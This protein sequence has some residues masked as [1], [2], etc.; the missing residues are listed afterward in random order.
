MACPYRLTDVCFMQAKRLQNPRPE[1]G[2]VCRNQLQLCQAR[3]A[4]V[5]ASQPRRRIWWRKVLLYLEK[6]MKRTRL[7]YI[8]VAKH[9]FPKRHWVWPPSLWRKMPTDRMRSQANRKWS[10]SLWAPPKLQAWT[11]Q[12]G[13]IQA[14]KRRPIQQRV[15]Q[16]SSLRNTFLGLHFSRFSSS[17]FE[18]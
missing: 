5:S 1:S 7:P 13:R 4:S 10:M 18:L 11:S 16:R 2:N 15:G 14:N 12:C 3:D 8:G 6:K 9:R 17:R